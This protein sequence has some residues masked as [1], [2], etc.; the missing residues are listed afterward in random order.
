MHVIYLCE[1]EKFNVPFSRVLE[2]IYLLKCFSY[3]PNYIIDWSEEIFQTIDIQYEI[4]A[5]LDLEDS[6]L[7]KHQRFFD[8]LYEQK[9]KYNLSE[10]DINLMKG[11][12]FCYFNIEGSDLPMLSFSTLNSLIP[13]N[14]LDIA[15]YQ[16]KNKCIY[17][18]TYLKLD[19]AITVSEIE[20]F[21]Q[22]NENKMLYEFYADYG[23]YILDKK[24]RPY[25]KII[26]LASEASKN[27]YLFNSF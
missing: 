17:F 8:L 4:A 9:E 20:K 2:K 26:N 22:E 23:N 24:N 15:Y 21:Y 12:F 10:N 18:N 16:A 3:L 13:K 19:N 11:V 1:Y 5:S 6:N 25:Q 7:E 14:E 27:G